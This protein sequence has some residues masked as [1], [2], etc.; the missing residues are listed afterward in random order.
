MISDVEEL[1][2]RHL[3]NDTNQ[4]IDGGSTSTIEGSHDELVTIEPDSGI[5]P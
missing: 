3:K 5:F 1:L 4:K 2:N